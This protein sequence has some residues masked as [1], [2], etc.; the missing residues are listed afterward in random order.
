MIK[1]L[2]KAVSGMA[3]ASAKLR[4]TL[5][6]NIGVGIKYTAVA[7]IRKNATKNSVLFNVLSFVLLLLQIILNSNT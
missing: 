5:L 1:A 2:R 6:G 3:E 7:K 4:I